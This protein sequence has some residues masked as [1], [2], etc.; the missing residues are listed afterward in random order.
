MMD[1]HGQNFE[2]R[3]IQR[4]EPPEGT[5]GSTWCHYVIKQGNNTIRGFRQGNL[6]TV[7]GEVKEIVKRLNDRRSGKRSFAAPRMRTKR[8]KNTKT[9]KH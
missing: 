5:D 6:K 1:E 4:T 8:T 3:S 7:R 2:I 9:T